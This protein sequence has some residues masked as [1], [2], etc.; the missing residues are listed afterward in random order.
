MEQIKDTT[1]SFMEKGKDLIEE[2]TAVITSAVE[3]GKEA[4]DKEKKKIVK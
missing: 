1:T 4:Y 3:A 2:Q